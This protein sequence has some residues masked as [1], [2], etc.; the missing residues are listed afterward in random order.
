M[1]RGGGGVF[2]DGGLDVVFISI[3]LRWG[4]ATCQLLKIQ[5]PLVLIKWLYLS[6][7]LL[8]P[9][10]LKIPLLSFNWHERRD[11]CMRVRGVFV[12]FP[13]LTTGT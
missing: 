2:A 6:T 11:Q 8:S 1:G 3:C 4:L 12:R 5:R 13:K 10:T 7:I 9:H